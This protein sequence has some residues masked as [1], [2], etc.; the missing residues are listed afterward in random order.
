MPTN[1][2]NMGQKGRELLSQLKTHRHELR[3]QEKYCRLHQGPLSL[4]VPT[5]GCEFYTYCQHCGGLYLSCNFSGHALAC[6][7]R[8]ST[9]QPAKN[10][11]SSSNGQ[12]L[13]GY[14][15]IPSQ[16]QAN[17]DQLSCFQQG[18]SQSA[19]SFPHLAFYQQDGSLNNQHLPQMPHPFQPNSAVNYY[20]N[21]QHGQMLINPTNMLMHHSS[22]IPTL[23][24]PSQTN[25]NQYTHGPQGTSQTQL[26]VN[27][28]PH[29]T[30]NQYQNALAYSSNQ[31]SQPQTYSD[32]WLFNRLQTLE[33]RVVELE[34]RLRA[35][36]NLHRTNND[37]INT[38]NSNS[39]KKSGRQTCRHDLENLVFGSSN[40][41]DDDDYT[42]QPYGSGT[43]TG[44]YDYTNASFGCQISY[45]TQKGGDSHIE[46]K[47]ALALGSVDDKKHEENCRRF[48]MPYTSTSYDNIAVSSND[49]VEQV[50]DECQIHTTSVEEKNQSS[51]EQAIDTL[52][53][54]VEN[55]QIT[56]GS[57]DSKQSYDSEEHVLNEFEPVDNRDWLDLYCRYVDNTVAVI[58]A[59][60]YKMQGTK[61]MEVDC[62]LVVNTLLSLGIKQEN[63][64]IL[65]G[66]AATVD[67]ILSALGK[68]R[69]IM[70]SKRE[71]EPSHLLIYYSGHSQRQSTNGPLF[72]ICPYDYEP[73]KPSKRILYGTLFSE[74]TC[75]A[76]HRTFIMDS[77]YSG[78]LL[79]GKGMNSLAFR[80]MKYHLSNKCVLVLT[81]ADDVEEG[82]FNTRS[83]SPF[84]AELCRYLQE[85]DASQ[86]HSKRPF[87]TL[88]DIY[89]HLSNIIMKTRPEY[90]RPYNVSTGT[91][92]I[93]QSIF[94]N[95][96]TSSLVS[97]LHKIGTIREQQ[98]QLKNMYVVQDRNKSLSMNYYYPI[99]DAEDDEAFGRLWTGATKIGNKLYTY[100]GE[101]SKKYVSD[102]RVLDTRTMKLATVEHE[103]KEFF[104]P[105]L[106]GH[107]MCTIR[108]ELLLFG[109]VD[110]NDMLQGTLYSYHTVSKLWSA[111]TV[112]PTHGP[113]SREGHNSVVI[114]DPVLCDFSMYVMFGRTNNGL[115]NDMYVYN[116]SSKEWRKISYGTCDANVPPPR[117]Y[118]STVF[119]RGKFYVIG[120]IKNQ[121]IRSELKMYVFNVEEEKWENPINLPHGDFDRGYS[122]HVAT[123]VHNKMIIVGGVSDS[124]PGDPHY[125]KSI[126]R[127]SLLA[128]EFESDYWMACADGMSGSRIGAAMQ[129]VDNRVFIF[130][131]NSERSSS[132]TDIYVLSI[133]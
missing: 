17:T 118:S 49:I 105:V 93:C 21:L 120:G 25:T 111:Q 33:N 88:S 129:N 2:S 59:V 32:N 4:C 102:L 9:S 47:S 97:S 34:N 76:K 29:L 101:K 35:C 112:S 87:F 74:T 82:E 69:E 14:Q 127:A 54:A 63:M 75:N 77:C 92:A 50:E 95:R 91:S 3:H 100:G 123:I 55:M 46:D 119:Y 116:D 89:C 64:L 109:G 133:R 117:Y 124:K 128:Y 40:D 11:P 51:D 27:Q 28:V 84:T 114:Y 7:P 48:G 110:N 43:A 132:G 26:Y 66:S 108:D 122:E 96:K 60:D 67:G 80:D 113:S 104:V 38:S 130:G 45:N 53:S 52:N 31:P 70:N 36:E 98:A 106:A 44:P 22:V 65:L 68:A 61:G 41:D 126:W 73:N 62:K 94:L 13:Y 78:G 1:R 56:K 86:A 23:L 15:G 72:Y 30:S 131:G 12:T 125:P 115:V 8:E 37:V 103:N 24:Q 42:S 81:S 85:G 90:G 83:G 58:I 79:H 57:D 10:Q 19:P 71:E 99:I 6:K 5:G 16:S 121:G 107:T 39:G 20:P 18:L